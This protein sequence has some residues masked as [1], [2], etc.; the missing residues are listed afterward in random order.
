MAADGPQDKTEWKA[1]GRS[2]SVKDRPDAVIDHLRPDE[3]RRFASFSK[4]AKQQQQN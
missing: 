4:A 1:L 2:V 3:I